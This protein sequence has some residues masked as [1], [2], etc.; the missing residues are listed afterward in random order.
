[1]IA[2]EMIAT[3]MIATE[4]I[5]TKRMNTNPAAWTTILRIPSDI[6]LKILCLVEGR[7]LDSFSFATRLPMR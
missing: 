2:T 3:E 7:Y 6:L 1:M 4:M 5:A